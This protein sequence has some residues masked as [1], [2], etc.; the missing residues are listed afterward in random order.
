MA[1]EQKKDAFL[2]CIGKDTFGLLRVLIALTKLVDKT[3]DELTTAL[4][5]H[6]S[7]KLLVIAERFRFHKREQKDGESIKTYA[8]S[9]QKLAE[10][11]NFGGALT[12]TLRDRLVCGMA[13]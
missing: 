8:A 9:L 6:L 5:T 10:H 3:Y 2:T 11:C 7:P 12:E 1:D 4:S 13:E